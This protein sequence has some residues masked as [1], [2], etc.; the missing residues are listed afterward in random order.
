MT[1]EKIIKREDGSEVKIYV[2]PPER[3]MTWDYLI[4]IKCIGNDGFE[5]IPRDSYHTVVLDA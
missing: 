3:K 2:F 1:H 5:W 4:E